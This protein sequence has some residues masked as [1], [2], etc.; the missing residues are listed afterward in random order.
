MS[1]LTV[2]VPATDRPAT[3]ARCR[4]AI[5]RAADT[6]VEVLVVDEPPDTGPAEARNLGAQRASGDVLV[7]IDADVEIHTDALALIRSAFERDPALTALFG[8]YDDAPDSA[9][10]VSAFR[11]LLHHHVHLEGAGAATT[12]WTGVGAVRR[13]AFLTAGGFDAERYPRPAIEDIELGMRLS[14]GGARIVLDPRIKGKHLKR[15][16]LSSMVRT[17]FWGRGVP[18]VELLLEHRSGSTALNLGWRHRLSTVACVVGL[19]A[20]LTGRHRAAAAA[21][22]SLLVLNR[23]FYGL[24]EQRLG[25]GGALVGSGLHAVHHLTGAAAVPFGIVRFLR[26]N[27]R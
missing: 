21:G 6:S 23:R 27:G 16:T 19:A 18:W 11:N 3:L 26:R 8:L 9:G 4:A 14:A 24:L 12:F 1:S 15:W 13:E 20:L 2:I 5:E 10:L 17:D 25:L 22:G 7:F